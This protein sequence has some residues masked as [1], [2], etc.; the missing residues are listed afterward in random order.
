MDG[1]QLKKELRSLY[2]SLDFV[3]ENFLS[4]RKANK[5]DGQI[6]FNIY[7]QLGLAWEFLGLQCKH[8][9]GYRTTRDRK[10]VCKICGKVKG[11]GESYYLLP[12]EGHK[13]IGLRRMPNSK[14]VFPTKAKAQIVNDTLDFH[15]ASLTMNVSNAYRS[16]LFNRKHDFAIAADRIVTLKERGIECWIDQ[17][18]IMV[19]MK[20]DRKRGA[21]FGGFPWEISR[22]QLK[23]FPVIF[24]YDKGNRFL[25]L[26]ILK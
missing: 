12:K 11:A 26:T 4:G 9:E 3:S 5:K 15:G 14:K 24:E 19:R 20:R 13:K 17:H 1:I 8:G 6:Y 21:I 18:L 25:G 2:K 23:H 7:Q 10:E 22:K 16:S